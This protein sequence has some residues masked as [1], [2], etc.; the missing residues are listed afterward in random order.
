VGQ[1]EYVDELSQ[2][3]TASWIFSSSTSTAIA[4]ELDLGLVA[5]QGGRAFVQDS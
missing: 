4:P 1:R 2:A 5:R 3:Q